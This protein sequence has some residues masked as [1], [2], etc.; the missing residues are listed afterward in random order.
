MTVVASLLALEAMTRT[1]LFHASKDL[2]RFTTYPARAR[3]LCKA[4]GRRVAFVGNSATERG[5]DLKEFAR[6]TGTVADEFVADATH[7]NS[8]IWMIQAEFWNQGI[9]P[10]VIVLSFYGKGLDDGNSIELGRLAQFFTT[11]RDW[12]DLFRNDVTA[13]DDRV[14]FTVSAMWATY[15]MR[16]RIKER[17]LDLLPGYVPYVQLQNSVLRA[18]DRKVVAHAPTRTTLARLLERARE[19]GTHLL[20]VAFPELRDVEA[21]PREVPEEVRR[22]IADAGMDYLDLRGVPGLTEAHYAD[23][24]H[25]KPEGRALYTRYLAERAGPLLR[26]P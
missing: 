24:I 22:M 9:S 1:K 14:D 3:A 10:D 6:L 26:R 16:D 20:F 19:H 4:E 25:L 15:A 18:H 5:V 7:V 8:W 11:R 21:P 17:M 23:T 13:F 12:G 2:S